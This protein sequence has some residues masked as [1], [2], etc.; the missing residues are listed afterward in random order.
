MATR[1]GCPPVFSST[2]GS[3]LAGSAS[4]AFTKVA[5]LGYADATGSRWETD[6]VYVTRGGADKI[7]KVAKV[8]GTFTDEV[9]FRQHAVAARERR[10]P[11]RLDEMPGASRD[12]CRARS[13]ARKRAR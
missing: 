4:D 10:R 6:V 9:S 5:D 13:E 7:V 1:S 3:R 8:D 12:R 11:A 2:K